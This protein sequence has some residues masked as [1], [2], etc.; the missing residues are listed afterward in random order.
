MPSAEDG[1]ERKPLLSSN[2]ESSTIVKR[3][4]QAGYGAGSSS[5][6]T[7]AE[8]AAPQALGFSGFDFR[9]KMLLLFL[10]VAGLLAALSVSILTPFFPRE[11]CF[12]SFIL[13]YTRM[14]VVSLVAHGSKIRKV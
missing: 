7:P 8:G 12:A 4:S 3:S 13:K 14:R 2:S 9:R 11:V 1:S 5:S 6:G 10:C